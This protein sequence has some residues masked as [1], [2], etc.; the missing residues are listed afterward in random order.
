MEYLVAFAI[1]QLQKSAETY[2]KRY[3]KSLEIRWKF[4]N[5]TCDSKYGMLIKSVQNSHFSYTFFWTFNIFFVLINEFW[6][7]RTGKCTTF[8]HHEYC[9]HGLY[10]ISH[11]NFSMYPTLYLQAKCEPY[12]KKIPAMMFSFSWF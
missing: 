11:H 8:Q 3:F 12:T 6:I 4:K 5:V 2:L 9:E 1:P 10:M 7:F